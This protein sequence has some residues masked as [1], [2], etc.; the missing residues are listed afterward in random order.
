MGA[1]KS[2]V[3]RILLRVGFPVY[4]SDSR[5]KFLLE[6]D[7]QLQA[8]VSAAFGSDLYDAQRRL[9]RNLL[10]ERAFPNSEATARLNAL[11]HPA[12]T[13]DFE[14]WCREQ[15]A[16]GYSIVFKEAALIFE[17]QTEDMLDAVWLVAAPLDLRRSRV[18]AREGL[19]LAQIDHRM[20]R[21]WPEEWKRERA[22]FVIE[23][24]GMKPLAPQLRLAFAQMKSKRAP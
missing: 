6:A 19:S 15:Q 4:N 8:E 13:Q 11:V 22:S 21:Q 1:G 2:H 18:Q 24:D 14:R 9:N 5:A 12:V 17:A 16:A 3:A 7:E 10:A 20:A 23:N